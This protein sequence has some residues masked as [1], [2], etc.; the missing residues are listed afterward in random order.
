MSSWHKETEAATVLA[1]AAMARADHGKDVRLVWR[2]SYFFFI[3]FEFLLL[4]EFIF[5]S[6]YL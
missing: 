4:K 1:R 6:V 5:N 3:F 2:N